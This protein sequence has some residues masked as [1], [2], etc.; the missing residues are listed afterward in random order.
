MKKIA[1]FNHKG[2]V[3]KSTTTFNLGWALAEAGNRVLIV[4]CDPQ[5]NLT[6]MVLALK[7]LDDLGDF[8][9]AHPSANLYTA[10]RRAFEGSPEKIVA[11]EIVETAQENLFLLPGHIDTGLFEPDL[12]MAH[13]LLGAMSILQNLPGA[14]GF[15]LDETAKAN[16]IDYVFLDMSPSVGALNQNL[17]VSCDYFIVPVAPDYFSYLAIDSLSK[18]LPRWAINAN[19]LRSRSGPQI[20]KL[21]ASNPRFMGIV[22]QRFNVR[23]GKVT[24]AYQK[25]I[26]KIVARCHES[27]IPSLQS[28]DMMLPEERYRSVLGDGW[29]IAQVPD[30]HGL[31]GK[32]QEHSKAVFAL[33]DDDL[34]M[35]GKVEKTYIASRDNFKEIFKSFAAKVVEL[36]K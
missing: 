18:T 8:Y 22:S 28:V 32:S 17:L 16:K 3:S 26:D 27:L 10:A 31:L 4:D 11:A 29:E 1:I 34:D 7:G 23:S 21:P 25:W 9:E 14:L 36:A 33:T 5:C 20:Y 12:A 13:K 19:E 6:G 2:G 30:F 15:L 35:S 24:N